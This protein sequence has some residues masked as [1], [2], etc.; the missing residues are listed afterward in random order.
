MRL[1][2]TDRT[3]AYLVPLISAYYVIRCLIDWD[4]QSRLALLRLFLPLAVFGVSVSIRLTV[5]RRDIPLFLCVLLICSFELVYGALQLFGICCSRNPDYIMTGSFSNPNPYAV[6]L[7]A[8]SCFLLSRQNGGR[9]GTLWNMSMAVAVVSLS[10]SAALE[11][12]SAIVGAAAGL[13]LAFRDDGLKDML[14]KR[15]YAVAILLLFVCAV[16]YVWKR[17]SAD[18]RLQLYGLCL[19]S[20][21][22]NGMIGAG[23]GHLVRSLFVEQRELFG[24]MATLSCG[25]PT[26]AGK[27]LDRIHLSQSMTYAFCDPLQVGVE[28]GPLAMLAFLVMMVCTIRSLY[29]DCRPL[30]SMGTVLV[31]ASMFTYVFEIWQFQIIGAFLT[32]Q[33]M[34]FKEPAKGQ[35]R[36]G[37]LPL[38]LTLA[39]VPAAVFIIGGVKIQNNWKG[40]RMERCLLD[41]EDYQVFADCESERF[42]VL[43]FDKYFLTEYAYALSRCG[44]LSASDSICDFGLAMIGSPSFLVLKGDNHVER[45]EYPQAREYYWR[46]FLTLPDR[47]LPLVRMARTYMLESDTVHLEAMKRFVRTFSTHVETESGKRLRDELEAMGSEP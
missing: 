13:Y 26:L 37:T 25:T 34:P 2:R 8:C 42:H 30:A 38:Y 6:F 16:L 41:G 39:I 18:G 28:L 5:G 7:A 45:E 40:W 14:S 21:K 33:A 11:C 20:M 32:G 36:T 3:L 4:C 27:A 44:K 46:A 1:T 24:E 35:N 12:R 17:P 47:L 9:S 43:G 10:V 31:T 29:H 23:P 19:D 22:R 15:R